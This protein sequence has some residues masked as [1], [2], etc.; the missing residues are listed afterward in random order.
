MLLSP[1]NYARIAIAKPGGPT[2]VSN[3]QLISNGAV[4]AWCR[5]GRISDINC[6]RKVAAMSGM[7][8]E[9][10]RPIL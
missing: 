7:G 6:A 10:L 1:E 8:V 4:H 5:K 3:Q 2:H 9:L